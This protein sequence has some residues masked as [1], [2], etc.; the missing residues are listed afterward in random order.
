MWGFG[1]KLRDGSRTKDYR[2][3]RL[4]D[5]DIRSRDWDIHRSVMGKPLRSYTWRCNQWLNQGAYGACVGF[6]FAHEICARPKEVHQGIT[7]EYALENIYF[8]AQRIDRWEGGEYPEASKKMAGTSVL[9]GA[10]TAR[11]LG[12]FKEFRWAFNT[13]DVLLTLGYK[14]PVVIGVSWHQGMMYTRDSGYIKAT[15]RK[16]GGHAV[17]LNGVN[18]KEKYVKVHNSWG[19]VWGENGEAKLSWDDLDSLLQNKGDACVPLKRRSNNHPTI[20]YKRK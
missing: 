9:A 17:L 13:N 8:N 16:I 10:K 11:D 1:K 4:V 6:S 19:K 14:G 2:L 5:F 15:G 20:K 12:W 7:N 3:D 18:T